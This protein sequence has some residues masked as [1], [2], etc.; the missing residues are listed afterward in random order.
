MTTYILGLDPRAME[1]INTAQ[2]HHIA[3][4]V[5][6]AEYPTKGIP[7]LLRGDIL[8]VGDQ[9]GN[10]WLHDT[11]TGKML[12]E[13]RDPH[14][15]HMNETVCVVLLRD[16]V[17]TIG[18][19]T[20]KLFNLPIPLCSPLSSPVV[21]HPDAMVT[22]PPRS[23]T[24]TTILPAVEHRWRWRIDSIRACPQIHA[25]AH[26]PAFSD[27]GPYPPINIFIRFG[28]WYPWPINMLYHFVLAPS[29]AAPTQSPNLALIEPPLVPSLDLAHE[30]PH[31][32]PG[33]TTTSTE[34]V[35]YVFPPVILRYTHSP[36]ELFA[37]VDTAVGPYGTALFTDSL[38]DLDTGPVAVGREEWQRVAGTMLYRGDERRQADADGS[39]VPQVETTM[40][41]GELPRPGA[42]L[43]AMDEEAG[44][45]AIAWKDGSISV[46]DYMPD[47]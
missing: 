25:Y 2:A 15:P 3:G 7:M 21:P 46:W 5:T 4:F 35:S 12:Y 13:L 10:V 31:L 18:P 30:H 28:S 11:I 44:R 19:S 42:Y 40:V 32:H 45:I 41:F 16:T 47:E 33:T 22:D 38:S 17:I 8:A 24:N 34:G 36:I 14:A 23:S 27:K 39:G 26:S 29:S 43:I 6:L 9:E 1:H 37:V 20:I